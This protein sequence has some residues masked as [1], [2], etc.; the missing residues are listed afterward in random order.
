[1]KKILALACLLT[2]SF[3]LWP[4][5]PVAN[6]DGPNKA[7]AAATV[8]DWVRTARIG[9][10]GVD[11]GMTD[12]EITSLMLVRKTENVSV[13]EVDSTLSNYKTEPQ[14]DQEVVFLNGIATKAHNNAMK[15]V[16]YYPSLEVL[17]PNGKNI[18]QT[19]Y[20][21][22]P[23]WVQYGINGNPN[24]FYGGK[25]HW[26]EPNMESAWMC[27]N[28]PYRDYY[29]NRIRKLAATSLDGV[30]ID[31]PIYIDT[32]VEWAGAGTYAAEAF[33]AW[34]ISKGL[35]L[36]G[37]LVTPT[38]VNWSST[39]FRA[40]VRWRHEN[41]A[42]FVD[43]VRIAA[44]EV[45]PQFVVIVETFP[46]DDMDTTGVGLDGTYR[47]STQNFI[48]VWENDSVSNSMA[49]QWSTGEDF[50]NKI[51][52]FKWARAVDRENPSWSFSYG[53]QPLDAGLTMAAAVATGNS[54]FEAKT[55]DMTTS[56]GTDF[57]SRWFGFIGNHQD[58]L[59]NTQRTAG[60]GIWYSSATKDYQ[61]FAVGGG[62][63]LY[64]TITPPTTDPDWWATTA[65][66]SAIPKPHL[67]DYRGAAHGLNQLAIPYKIIADP[68]APAS[69]LSGVSL[70]WLPSVA[71]ISDA[72]ATIL[73]NFVTNGGTVLATGTLPGQLDEWGNTRGAN[74]LAD[75]FAFTGSPPVASTHQ[76]GLGV[77][78][79]RPDL[80][81]SAMFGLVGNP[82]LASQ[83]LSAING[84]VRT[85]VPDT[86]RVGSATGLLI[87]VSAPSPQ[88][89]VQL[90]VVNYSG[91]KV[92]AVAN[93]QNLHLQY[94][95]PTGFQV[96]SASAATPDTGGQAGQLTVTT[97]AEGFFGIDVLIDQFALITVTLS[98]GGGTTPPSVTTNSAS[99]ITTGG[100][101]LNGNLSALG[102]ATT[103]TVSFE[104]GL[105]TG[106]G[107]TAAGVPPTRTS[108]GTFGANVTGLA[109]N[110]LY[111]F[112]A[113]AVGNG[114]TYGLDQTFTTGATPPA[115]TTSAATGITTS[116]AT[117]N[118]NLS[119]LGTAT[120]VT[121]SFE[122]GL[123][124]SYGGTAAGVPPTRTS[125]G[126]FGAN[127][128]GLA[129][130]TLYHFR[131]KAVGSA[132][133]YGL[134]QAFATGTTPPAVATGGATG[135]TSSSAIL[136]GNL[137]AIGSTSPVSVSLQW[138]NAPGSYTGETATQ[139][140]S[141]AATF[142]ASV[143]GLSASTTYYFRA[144]A[145]GGI[146][147]TSYGTE[148]TFVTP[149]AV[150]TPSGGGGMTGGG[151]YGGPGPSGPGVTALAIYT[152][153][154]GLFNLPA[155]IKSDD[156]KVTLGINQ[157]VRV[158]T[159]EGESPNS[160]SIV[161][162]ASQAGVA[163]DIKF[164][165][166]AY[167]FGP[168]GAAFSSSVVLTIFYDPAR[169]ATEIDPGSLT[170]MWFN[171]R[172]TR[173]EPLPSSHNRTNYSV[174]ASIDHLS[175]YVLAGKIAAPAASPLPPS[176]TTGPASFT[177]TGVTASPATT[178]AGQPISISAKVSNTGGTSG[179]YEIILKVNGT[180]DATKKINLGAGSSSVVTLAVTKHAAGE[181]AV[182]VNGATGSFTIAD[183]KPPATIAPQPTPTTSPP[184]RRDTSSAWIIAV[185]AGVLILASGMLGF[186][187][188]RRRR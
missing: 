174:T 49:M 81:A 125:T 147:G 117:L 144:K 79:Y 31:V 119:A 42:E 47:L 165:S 73:K 85:Y 15:A 57:R 68:G 159:K 180:V 24:V 126:T 53:N 162:A 100:A 48:R 101:T 67:G 121:V 7:L 71:A 130:N 112:R 111:H 29:L 114:T 60:V 181:Y 132:T 137:T 133:T 54:P 43:A 3:S 120:T 116:G 141:A 13:L 35:G 168:D 36:P 146:S 113:K 166:L 158:R 32:V 152:N 1:V 92:P 94:K 186:Q 179:E 12:A 118:G 136:S 40:W 131:A 14:F 151:S 33:R 20:K 34:S 171:A 106:Y 18:A 97:E 84:I 178:M 17:T 154:D 164:V 78:I 91:L 185:V 177:I 138:G 62:F 99:S 188:V 163:A 65:D 45:N 6:N 98:S 129:A 21:E 143:N 90:Y 55:P 140:L 56:V 124:T 145:N 22:H 38:Q 102:T 64:V 80:D 19:M 5:G 122:Y 11:S 155:T 135:I 173:W 183:P 82:T 109:A 8:P 10:F 41:L 69:E 150:P 23:T 175:M 75:L 87:E 58:A 139:P 50:D 46:I 142:N 95:P 16:I 25:E 149:A 89:Q 28:S 115:V 176:P 27:P 37:G 2:L 63:G 61:D 93:P 74:I 51:A 123:T 104:Y 70:V 86:I 148:R 167:E 160:I 108:T 107:S 9:G 153:G 172:D 161:P 128:T 83:T 157:G 59:L 39:T 52:M 127:V 88:D 103:V 77:A 169:L 96:T 184:A 134:D 170:I 105:T 4:S 30:W 156:A 44:Q 26:V 110:T 76:Y 72:S 182:D 66:S 187:R